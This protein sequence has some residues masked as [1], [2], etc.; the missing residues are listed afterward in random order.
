VF[1]KRIGGRCTVT[2]ALLP[3]KTMK[4]LARAMKN[5]N[6]ETRAIVIAVE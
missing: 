4:A 1:A 6:I 3:R 2:Q 5:I